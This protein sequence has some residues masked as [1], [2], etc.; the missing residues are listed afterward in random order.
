MSARFA[1]LVVEQTWDETTRRHNA[2]N[3][4]AIYKLAKKV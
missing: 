4:D 1:R 2:A 3:T